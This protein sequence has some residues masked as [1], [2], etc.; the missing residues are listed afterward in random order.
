MTKEKSALN[1]APEVENSSFVDNK[2][3]T[4]KDKKTGLQW[5]Q[6]HCAVI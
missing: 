4:V 3:N 6:D 2:D 5:I 1:A